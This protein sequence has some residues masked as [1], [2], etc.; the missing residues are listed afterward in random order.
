MNKDVRVEILTANS[1]NVA[2]LWDV[3]PWFIALKMEAISS[4]ETKSISTRLQGATS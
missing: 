1:M 4:S 3:A 2:V